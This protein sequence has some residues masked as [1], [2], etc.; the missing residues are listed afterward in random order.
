MADILLDALPELLER[1]VQLALL[2]QGDPVLEALLRDMTLRYPGRMS[3][4]IGYE[5]ALAHRF[6]AGGDVLLHPSR[7]EPCGLTPLYALRYGTLPVVRHVGGL[8]DTIFDADEQSIRGEAAN[9]F[10]F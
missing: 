10:G 8:L 5:E 4:R 3:V 7:F 9:G 1:D 2:G 6:Y